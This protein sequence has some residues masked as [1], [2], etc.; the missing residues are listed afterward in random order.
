MDGQTFESGEDVKRYEDEESFMWL[1]MIALYY[2]LDDRS[3]AQN[4]LKRL[5]QLKKADHRG[6]VMAPHSNRAHR[7]SMAVIQESM[8]GK[9]RC[10]H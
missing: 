10:R 4:G 5:C 1:P 6:R 8:P 9:N 7:G 2:K 3:A